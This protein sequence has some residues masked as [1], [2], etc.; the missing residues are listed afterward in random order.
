MTQYQY[1]WSCVPLQ[2]HRRPARWFHADR[3]LREFFSEV[4]TRCVL[5]NL[6]PALVFVCRK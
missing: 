2:L 1:V 4:N 6:P 5:L 3:F